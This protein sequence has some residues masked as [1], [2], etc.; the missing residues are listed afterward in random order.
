M[1]LFMLANIDFT[2]MPNEPALLTRR[3][4]MGSIGSL[5]KAIDRQS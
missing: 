1:A 4:Q 2:L 5:N 3:S